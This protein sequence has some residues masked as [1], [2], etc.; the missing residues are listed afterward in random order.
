MRAPFEATTHYQLAVKIKSGKLDR[1]P[2]CYSDNLMQCIH[3]MLQQ[4]PDRRPSADQL[5]E[6]EQIAIR[7]QEKSQFDRYSKLKRKEAELS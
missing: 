4:D 1:I 5:L 7:I 3:A 2:R 6:H